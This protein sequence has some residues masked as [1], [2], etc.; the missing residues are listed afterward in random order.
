MVF[1][2]T[3]VLPSEVGVYLSVSVTEGDGT[4]YGG[5]YYSSVSLL[6]RDV[7][8]GFLKGRSWGRSNKDVGI[9]PFNV[10]EWRLQSACS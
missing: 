5:C 10:P 7:V 4:E 6:Q 2:D 9:R 1:I 8:V 3:R